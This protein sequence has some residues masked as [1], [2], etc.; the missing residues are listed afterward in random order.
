MC[1]VRFAPLA[2]A[3]LSASLLLL[4][5][6]AALASG[7]EPATT[8]TDSDGAPAAAPPAAPGPAAG[9]AATP[10]IAR[11]APASPGEERGTHLRS[12][13]L[14]VTGMVFDTAGA[15]A[16]GIGAAVILAAQDCGRSRASY[17]GS[18]GWEGP[19]YDSGST[20]VSTLL[21]DLIGIGII[22]AGSVLL[23]IGI[24]LTVVGAKTVPDAPRV[25]KPSKQA[26]PSLQLTGGGFR[27]TF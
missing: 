19:I 3:V 20:C 5:P 8:A 13:P 25:P 17:D 11:P 18:N 15:A 26:G 4:I 9:P 6:S 1:V 27:G 12:I 22:G 7:D 16:V 10:E 2:G 14:M 23:A 21:L 24:P